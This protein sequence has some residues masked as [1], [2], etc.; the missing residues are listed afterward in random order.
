M[1]KNYEKAK[2][3]IRDKGICR[4]V[5]DSKL[6]VDMLTNWEYLPK[7]ELEDLVERNKKKF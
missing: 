6:F 7:K 2:K 3:I 1:N 5:E 4:S